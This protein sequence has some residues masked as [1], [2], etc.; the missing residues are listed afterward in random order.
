MLLHSGLLLPVHCLQAHAARDPHNSDYILV[1]RIIGMPGDVIVFV[2]VVVFCLPDY[3][4]QNGGIPRSIRAGAY[5]I[6]LGGGR[7][8]ECQRRQQLLWAGM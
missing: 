8:Q 3:D 6:L 2:T 7:Q 5:R 4:L 1:K